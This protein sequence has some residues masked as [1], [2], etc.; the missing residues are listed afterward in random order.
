M[1]RRPR[2]SR[3]RRVGA[4]AAAGRFPGWAELVEA[5]VSHAPQQNPVTLEAQALQLGVCP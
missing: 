5:V 2:S 1:A 4:A 3:W